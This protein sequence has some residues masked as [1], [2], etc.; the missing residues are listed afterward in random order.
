[1]HSSDA[2]HCNDEQFRQNWHQFLK[3]PASAAVREE[4][5]TSWA[6][7][8]IG[9]FI[10]LIAGLI[11]LVTI[12]WTLDGLKALRSV[13]T[14]EPFGALRDNPVRNPDGYQPIL[15]FGII[16]GPDQKHALALATFKPAREVSLDQ[17]AR[18]AGE[19]GILYIG[20]SDDP[21]DQESFQLLRD[22]TY[23][24]YRRRRVPA[25]YDAGLDLWLLDVEI[26]LKEARVTPYDVVAIAMIARKGDSGPIAQLPWAVAQGAV[27][28]LESDVTVVD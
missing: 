2:I 4:L 16:I 6:L 22:D 23:R 7:C 25:R 17:V 28:I 14:F 11:M 20:G 5:E 24:A 1:M 21:A 26:D 9:W 10:L 8:F 27:D 19:L 18:I 13:I 3:H 15:A 12:R